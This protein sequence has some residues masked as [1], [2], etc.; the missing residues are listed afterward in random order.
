MRLFLGIPLPEAVVGELSTITA[1]LRS[2]DDG[3]RWSEPESWH[4]TLQ[5]LGNTSQEQYSCLAVRLRNLHSQ[6]V[7]LR[8]ASLNV[9]DRAGVLFVEV[10]LTHG[11]IALQQAVTEATA[12][13]G[14]APE[15]R[16]YH[17]HI[18][19]ARAKGT[20]SKPALRRLQPGFQ[21]PRFSSFSA[22]E[23]LLYESILSSDGSRYI[24]REHFRLR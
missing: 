11:L 13:C 18:T 1:R 7:S 15:A 17:P 24:I 2:R 9:F 21:Q 19:L 16:E 6:P 14:F 5:F 23:F 4:V 22:Q 12:P 20:A 3:L 8:L 10:Q